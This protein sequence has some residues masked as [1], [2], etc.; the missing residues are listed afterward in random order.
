MSRVTNGLAAMSA[1]AAL[2]AGCG[3]D[4]TPLPEEPEAAPSSAPAAS[5][6]TP[7]DSD[8]ASYEPS[9][10]ITGKVAEIESRGRL[11]VG[12]SADTYLMAS[13]NPDEGNRIEGFDI[14]FAKAIGR[15]IFGSD[16]ETGR[17][18]ELRVITAADRI[19][20][21]EEEA[22]DLVIRNFTIN[23]ARWEQI[24]FS[25]VYYAATQKV[26]V[27]RSLDDGDEGNGEYQDPSDLAGLRVCAPTGSTSLDNIKEAEEEA[28]IEPAANHT[29]CLVKFQRG[30]VDAITGD[31]TVLAGLAAQDPYAVVPEQAPLND[32]PYGI[33]ANKDDTELVAFVNGVLESMRENDQWQPI[34]TRWLKSALNGADAV[35]PPPTLPYR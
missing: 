30:E 23:C 27:S 5:T 1:M 10:E 17:N 15:A 35:Q 11:I 9:D 29:G 26:L 33:G 7:S 18:L 21:L 28:I 12:V 13:E 24:A 6:C 20:L 25:Q 34:Y 32:E 22:V 3:Y 8:F 19:P 14:E 2:L 4:E 31:D 16:F